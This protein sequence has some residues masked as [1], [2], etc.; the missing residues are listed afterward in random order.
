MYGDKPRRWSD[1]L[2]G[3]KRRRYI[4]NSLTRMR[5]IRTNGALDFS[6]TGPPDDAAKGLH[7]WYA[8]RNAKWRGT[9]IVFGHWS[10]L[11]LMVNEQVIAI[12]TGCVWGRQMSAVRLDRGPAVVQVQC[13][14]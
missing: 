5:M 14:P 13:K 6:H 3:H 7:P 9:R 4:V 2:T 10:A 8:A 12:D 1:N 11:G